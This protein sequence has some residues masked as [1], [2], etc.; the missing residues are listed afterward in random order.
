MTKQSWKNIRR[1]DAPIRGSAATASTIA[2]RT[3][4]CKFGHFLS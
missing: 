2:N 1:I 3:M 4:L